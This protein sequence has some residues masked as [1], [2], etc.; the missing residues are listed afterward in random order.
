MNQYLN[1]GTLSKHIEQL[2]ENKREPGSFRAPVDLSGRLELVGVD[3]VRDVL[4]SRVVVAT[5]RH[6]PPVVAAEAHARDERR[7]A[8]V[9]LPGGVVVHHGVVEQLH[10]AHVVA[11]HAVLLRRIKEIKTR[12]PLKKY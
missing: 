8:M 7:A 3:A 9:L 1:K 2:F 11:R 10:G 12:D 6:H 5:H 4:K